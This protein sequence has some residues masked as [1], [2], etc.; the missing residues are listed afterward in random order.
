[1]NNREK[2]E[3][4]VIS[5]S[6]YNGNDTE[7]LLKEIEDVYKKAQAFDEILEGMTNAIQHSVKE[8]IELDE[9]IGIMVSQVIYEYKEELENEKI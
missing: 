9:A 5:A 8:G 4:S 1:M 3:Q 2:I 7:G 6:A